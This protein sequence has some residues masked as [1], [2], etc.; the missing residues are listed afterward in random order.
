MD[1]ISHPLAIARGLL[2]YGVKRCFVINI[3]AGKEAFD[4]IITNF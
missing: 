3:F 1:D 2:G 4:I